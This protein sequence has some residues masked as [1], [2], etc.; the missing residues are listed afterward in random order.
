MLWFVIR[1]LLSLG[2]R[3]LLHTHFGNA[4]LVASAARLI[5]PETAERAFIYVS[6]MRIEELVL[7]GMLIS[8]CR[9]DHGC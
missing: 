8:H 2:A 6:F 3:Y 4:L 7:E 9:N 5:A 1:Y